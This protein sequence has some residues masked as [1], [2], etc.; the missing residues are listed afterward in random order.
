MNTPYQMDLFDLEEKTYQPVA[1]GNPYAAAIIYYCPKCKAFVGQY[2]KEGKD[3]GWHFV[4]DVC[5]NGHKLNW[6]YIKNE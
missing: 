6:E 2:S 4:R 3:K 1:S 5:K